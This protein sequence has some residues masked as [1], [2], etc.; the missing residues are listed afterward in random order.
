M[1]TTGRVAFVT[2][3][4][5]SSVLSVGIMQPRLYSKWLRKESKQDPRKYTTGMTPVV[6]SRENV[7]DIRVLWCYLGRALDE[8]LFNDKYCCTKVSLYC[9]YWV[10]LTDT[11]KTQQ[12]DCEHG[13]SVHLFSLSLSLWSAFL[14]SLSICERIQLLRTMLGAS[15]WPPQFGKLGDLFVW[16]ER[17]FCCYWSDSSL[18]YL[19]PF[20][21]SAVGSK[22]GTATSTKPMGF[23]WRE[24]PESCRL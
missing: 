23:G 22:K 24:S 11:R 2:Q 1:N 21:A 16:Q 7:C 5:I 10:W 13:D 18:C 14:S 19:I 17:S 8:G 12:H 20:T 3:V 4:Y 9:Y 15:A 6:A